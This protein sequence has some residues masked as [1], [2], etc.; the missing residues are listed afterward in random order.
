MA[1][2]GEIN[3]DTVIV[4]DFNTKLSIMNRKA[5]PKIKEMEY[6]NPII[7]ICQKY[8]NKPTEPRLPTIQ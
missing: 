2:G 4:G 1:K 5:R 7:Q 3:N 6:L 8:L